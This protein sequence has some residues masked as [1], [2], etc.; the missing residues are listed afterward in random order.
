MD[1]GLEVVLLNEQ[2]RAKVNFLNDFLI[3]AIR[4]YNQLFGNE[5]ILQTF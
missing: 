5:R 2:A 1:I 3:A 4:V